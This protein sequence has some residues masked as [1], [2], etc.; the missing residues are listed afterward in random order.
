MDLQR[1]YDIMYLF[2]GSP[3]QSSLA[4][5]PQPLGPEILSLAQSI[6]Q[7]TLHLFIFNLNWSVLH[8]L[9]SSHTLALSVYLFCRAFLVME[10]LVLPSD[11]LH[12]RDLGYLG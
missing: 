8:F 11:V 9:F 6:F 10:M 12:V 4:L 2:V 5:R 3:L 7:V 1:D